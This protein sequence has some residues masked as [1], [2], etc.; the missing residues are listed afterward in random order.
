[1]M[2]THE[3]LNLRVIRQR[4]TGY[5]AQRLVV[6][7]NRQAAVAMVLR[8]MDPHVEL[9]LI[10]RARRNGDPWSGQMGFPGGMVAPSD[11][12][13]QAAAE[14]ETSEEIGLT[15]A[16]RDYLGRI[17]DMQGRHRGHPSGIIVSAYVYVVTGGFKPYL[18]YEVRDLLWVP[19]PVFSE[20]MR[21]VEVWNPAAPEQ[22][23]PGIRVSDNYSQV[24]WGLTHRFLETFFR[25]VDAEFVGTGN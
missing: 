22:C 21:V 3:Y 11:Y 20:H 18:N 8:Q 17:D 12:D 16:A 24:V 13:A 5:S 9:L 10:E 6:G 15:L 1:M 7:D 23:F 2:T 25:L 19:L 4:L 14:R